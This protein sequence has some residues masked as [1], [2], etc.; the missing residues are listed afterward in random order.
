MGLYGLGM[1]TGVNY[2]MALVWGGGGGCWF[3]HKDVANKP[4]VQRLNLIS[5]CHIAR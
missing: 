3:P 1:Q 4:L 5:Q 2:S